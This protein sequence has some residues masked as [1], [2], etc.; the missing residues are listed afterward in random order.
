VRNSNLFRILGYFKDLRWRV[1]GVVIVGSLSIVMFAFMP[2]FLKGAFDTLRAWLG[3]GGVS[4]P[5]SSVIQQLLIFGILAL[6]NALFD[7][8]CTFMIL[9]YENDTMINKLVEVKRK[10]DV[11]PTSFLEKFTVGDL[12]RRMRNM[13]SVILKNF[14]VTI[15]TIARISVFFITTSIM[16]FTINW[17]LA[18]VVVLSLPLC[19]IVSRIVSKRTQKYFNKYTVTSSGPYSYIDQ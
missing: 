11:V 16:M 15:Y 17:I 3:E 1:L 9:K 12:S 4:A 10:L 7:I 6:F 18:I 19:I 14:L 8:F 5:M 2:S 13:T